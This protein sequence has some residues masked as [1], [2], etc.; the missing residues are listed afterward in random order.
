DAD[1]FSFT[2][3]GGAR[4]GDP[5]D[6]VDKFDTIS[7]SIDSLD[8]LIA[9]YESSLA[10]FNASQT[11]S[12]LTT[13]QNDANAVITQAKQ[14]VNN[15]L[16][17]INGGVLE[18]LIGA[19]ANI[20]IPSKKFGMAVFADGRTGGGI[21]PVF[22]SQ[23][24]TTINNDIITPLETFVNS[25][26]TAPTVAKPTYTSEIRVIA[27]AI[28]EVGLTLARKFDFANGIAI[29]ISPK[30]IK[31]TT[32]DG[33]VNV[34][35]ADNI[36]DKIDDFKK[37]HTSAN[38]DLGLLKIFDSGWRFGL[39]IKNLIPE[40]FDTTRGRQIKFSPQ[41]RAGIAYNG[42]WAKFAVDMDLTENNPLGSES[43]TE[44]IAI[45][46][47]LDLKL[48]QL[49]LGYRDNLSEKSDADEG[50]F[51]VGVGIYLGFH[52]DAAVAGNSDDIAGSV[53][54]GLTF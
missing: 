30:I 16:P 46:T 32:F 44:F 11:S 21:V 17:A 20:A 6:L 18:F 39:T 26:G 40:E 29:G 49:R 10:T 33:F 53:Q 28:S 23:D 54:V 25:G 9:T 50:I 38:V 48:L 42:S 37:S 5:N 4:A 41:A 19:G 3:S 43:G 45:G 2:V 52:L 36:D 31:V 22:S 8:S 35:N 15:D 13:V 14:V 51:S 24:Q 7:T 47:E 12:N 34:N 27:S 1:D